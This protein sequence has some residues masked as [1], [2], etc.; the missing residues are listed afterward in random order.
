VPSLKDQ[1]EQLQKLKRRLAIWEA[2]HYLVD[3]KFV[4]K[5][6]RKV[7]GIKVPGTGDLVPEEEI[8]DV[9]QNIGEGPIEDLRAEIDAIESLE[10][11]ILGEN[12]ASA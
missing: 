10:V 11:V 5:D 7:S 6:G 9:L 4:S 1:L 2:V 3:E 12:K 8:E